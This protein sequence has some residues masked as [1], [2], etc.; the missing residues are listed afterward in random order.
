MCQASGELVHDINLRRVNLF[1]VINVVLQVVILSCMKMDRDDNPC[2]LCGIV[3]P[4]ILFPPNGAFQVTYNW[5]NQSFQGPLLSS[6][7]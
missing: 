3:I 5:Y 7:A 2:M 1:K 4:R 6:M